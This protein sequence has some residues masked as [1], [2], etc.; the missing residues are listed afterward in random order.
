LRTEQLAFSKEEVA[1]LLRERSGLRMGRAD[2]DELLEREACAL[3]EGFKLKSHVRSLYRKLSVSS[4]KEAVE[5]A[6]ARKLI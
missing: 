2:I 4:R 1:S 3:V 5:Q 6:F